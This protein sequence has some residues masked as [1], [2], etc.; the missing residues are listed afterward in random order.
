MSEVP[1]VEVQSWAVAFESLILSS[2]N[3]PDST[4]TLY[5]DEL[6]YDEA[7]SDYEVVDAYLAVPWNRLW[8][9]STLNPRY[10]RLPQ[11]SYV[12]V[13]GDCFRKLL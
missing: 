11:Q 3:G 12:V 8:N 2:W 4:V 7:A 6:P 10:F 5:R 9:Y 13:G 1:V